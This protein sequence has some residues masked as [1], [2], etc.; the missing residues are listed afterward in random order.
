MAEDDKAMT[1]KERLIAAKRAAVD[2]EIAGETPA[3]APKAKSDGET[4]A[5]PPDPKP[6][7]KPAAASKPEPAKADA[8]PKSNVADDADDDHAGDHGDDHGDHG[9]HDG[10]HRRS[11]SSV[12][13]QWIVIFFVGAAAALWAGPRLAPHLP[14]WASPVA[15][16]LTPGADAAAEA[17]AAVR[18]DAEAGLS[19]LEER[20]ETMRAETSAASATSAAAAAS[21]DDAVKTAA[22]AVAAAETRLA[23]RIDELAASPGA[24]EGEVA[25]LAGRLSATE[26]ALDGLRTQLD[27]L[28][29]FTSED[30]VAPSAEM[31]AQV[32]AFGAAVEG[33]RAEVAA[34]SESTARI[35]ALARQ[36]EV[37]ALSGTVG[38]IDERVVA[39]EGGQAATAAAEAEADRIKREANLAGALARIEAAIATGEPF[40]DPLSTA[41]SLSGEAAP[42]GLSAA[43][44]GVPTTDDL[45]ADF[46]AAAQD[47]Y[48]AA[49]ASEAGEGLG[50]RFL[51]RL[52]GRLG[53]RPT[54]ETE[55]DGVGAVLSRIEAR[56]RE[57]QFAAALDEA[58]ALP[59]PA[60]AAMSDW[61]G[62]LSA[63]QGAKQGLADWRAALTGQ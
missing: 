5:P 36:E 11:L 6:D 58:A 15:K 22:A 45:L 57:A 21:A 32:A 25:A 63:A 33:L 52:E 54:E 24:D 48:A 51:A 28:T 39:L 1:A 35:D 43:A 62:G 16:F 40:A 12:L 37:A 2:A 47:A 60:G 10:H 41:V 49:L 59:E 61:L 30:G 46:P 31:L 8:P 56:V 4:K 20:L 44:S 9:D 3:A 55:G 13:L 7:P 34:L 26:A 38:A 19:A 53:G 50:Q 23:G 29:G 17:V 18:A 14:E 27:S 42:D